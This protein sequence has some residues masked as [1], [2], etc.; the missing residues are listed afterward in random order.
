VCPGKILIVIAFQYF[1]VAGYCL[2]Q[3]RHFFVRNLL[4]SVLHE[5]P[6]KVKQGQLLHSGLVICFVY[7]TENF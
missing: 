2:A 6:G 4:T 1:V 7:L 3:L 5:H